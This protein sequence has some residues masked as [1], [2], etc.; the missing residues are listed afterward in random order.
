LSNRTSRRAPGPR[1]R[2]SSFDPPP[3]VQT[4]GLTALAAL[5]LFCFWSC[6]A[7][8]QE[9]PESAPAIPAKLE[10]DLDARG[11]AAVALNIF[12][13]QI[14]SPL[15]PVMAQVAGC[16][17]VNPKDR[18]A[19]GDWV[20]SGRCSGALLK[21]GLLIGG[22]LRF[23]PLLQFLKQAG[24]DKLDVVIRHPRTAFSAF[25]ES[26]W[27]VETTAQSVE[28]LR[29]LNTS[30]VPGEPVRLAFGY[31]P[32]NF[33]ALTLLLFPVGLALIMRLVALRAKNT[34]PVVIWFTYW[35]LL[36][37]VITGSWLLWVQGSTVFDCA[38][39]ARFLLNGASWA[40]VLQVAFYLVPPVLVQLICTISSGAVLARVSGERWVLPVSIKHA[41]WHEPVTIWPV[42]CLLAGVASLALYNE[43]LLGLAC[44]AIA[45]GAHRLLVWLWLR[46]E[47]LGRYSLPPGELCSRILELAEKSGVRL[48]EIYLLPA[49]EGRLAGPYMLRRRRLFLSDALLRMFRKP[50]TEALLAR[51]FMQVR[52]HHR[53][54]L[55]GAAVASLPLI[56][57]FSHL[58]WIAG[59]LPWAVR[60]PLLVWLTPV[61]LYWLWRRFERDAEERAAVVTG[62]AET[63]RE[64]VAKVAQLNTLEAYW[65]RFERRFLANFG[66]RKS[67]AVISVPAR[68]AVD[69]GDPHKVV[70]GD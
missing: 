43:F 39:L 49:A 4:R 22:Q 5:C 57:R 68:A 45:Y 7:R 8:A 35:R 56:Y 62:D 31:R 46:F 25:T 61:A 63:L 2:R 11:G 21:R 70:S 58:S 51:E 69:P 65:R 59:V 54:I 16:L 28:Y 41:F 37:W 18:E 52:R 24:V 48:E 29:S 67:S 17:F 3:N 32:A 10:I 23:A 27:T 14:S 1:L 9:E 19:N 6:T 33:L 13:R 53:E 15:Q 44:L 47:N 34:E 55:L 30:T 36:G 64:A 38:A 26:G 66:D 12:E 60:G 50:E 40:P 20:F 42:L